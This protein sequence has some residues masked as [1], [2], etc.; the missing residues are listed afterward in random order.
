MT[1]TTTTPVKITASINNP[2]KRAGL[3][4]CRPQPLLSAAPQLPEGSKRGGGL[5]GATEAD[6]FIV[7][8]LP[9]NAGRSFG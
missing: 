4:M 3:Y 9:M 2:D 5:R 8:Q 7:N 6:D 1:P